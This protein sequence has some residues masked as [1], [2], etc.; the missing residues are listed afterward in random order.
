MMRTRKQT[1]RCEAE[2]GAALLI[3]I[4]ALLLISVVAI[5][6]VVSSGTDAALGGNY[7]TSAGAY[8]AGVAGL[9]EA[10]GRL[11]WKNPDYLNKTNAFPTLLAPNGLPTWGP[12]QVFYIK[13]PA[14]GETVDPLSANPVD[15]PDTEYATEFTG[16]LGGANVQWVTSVSPVTA[17]LP[18]PSYKWAR[19]TPATEKSLNIDVDGDGSVDPSSNVRLFYEPA[20][21]DSSCKPRPGLVPEGK[22]VSVVCGSTIASPTPAAVQVLEITALSVVPSGGRRLLQYVV[23]P[24]VISPD[25]ADQNFPA[26]L[27]IAGPGSTYQFSGTPNYKIDGRD[28]CS[29][30]TPQ[31]SVQA[32]G[33]TDPAFYGVTFP[34]VLPGKNNYPGYPLV[35]SGP[36][37]PTYMPTTPSI[38]NVPSVLQQSWQNPGALNAVMQDVTNSADVVLTGPSTGADISTHA[39]TMSNSNPMTIVVNGDLNLTGLVNPGF[40]LLVV[41]GRLT[42]DPRVTWNGLVL[43]VGQG[44]FA[45]NA[46]ITGSGGFQGAILVAKTLDNSGNVL[47]G[48]QLG[49]A[50]FISTGTS[51]NLGI[52]YNSCVARSAQGPLA[53]KV[54]SFR[55][56]ALAN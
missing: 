45:Y 26:A 53:Y 47:G 4:F 50:S 41:T 52:T 37:P 3:A 25:Y 19:I 18:G 13:N 44:N 10:R 56:I 12:T 38:S 1:W 22:L 21:L 17:P 30:T 6:L 36:P 15:Y 43:V 5:A 29:A 42:S 2:S 46:G 51:T 39:P 31:G 16:G 28:A 27:T 11:L 55:E 32:I 54:L 23:A 48:T 35:P 33:Y 24:L 49:S 34:Q 9:E 7:R 14:G 20:N 8:F 40:G